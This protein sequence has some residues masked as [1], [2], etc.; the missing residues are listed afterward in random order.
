MIRNRTQFNLSLG[1]EEH[2]WL[3]AKAERTGVSACAYIRGLI[4][5]EIMKES[6]LA[7]WKKNGPPCI[8]EFIAA[9]EG[10]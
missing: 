2:G 10:E 6:N 5:R 1:A 3:K 9:R 4:R 7:Y 8:R